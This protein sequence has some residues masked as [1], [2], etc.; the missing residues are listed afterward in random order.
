MEVENFIE[1]QHYEITR[2]LLSECHQ[3]ITQTLPEREASIKWK[4]P[5][6]YFAKRP[7]C[8]LT[9]KRNEVIVGFV[10]GIHLSNEQQLLIGEQ[11][12]VRHFLVKDIETIW[13]DALIGTLLEAA[14]F[15]V[16]T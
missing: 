8:Y 16:K 2:L 5:F 9:P 13:S 10:Q 4:I 1:H 15:N 14:D 6:Y 11:K 3:M 12:Q 7:L